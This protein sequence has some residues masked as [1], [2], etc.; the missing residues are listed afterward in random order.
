MRSTPLEG[1]LS[2]FLIVTRDNERIRYSGVYLRRLEATNDEYLTISSH[3]LVSVTVDISNAYNM[4]NP[5]HY[6]IVYTSPIHYKQHSVI[7]D[8]A[9]VTVTDQFTP[10]SS[11][12]VVITGAASDNTIGGLV[13]AFSHRYNYPCKIYSRGSVLLSLYTMTV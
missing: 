10:Y 9:S 3:S 12:K 8:T 5:G 7:A 13:K 2:E 11:S 6:S 4:N 1:L